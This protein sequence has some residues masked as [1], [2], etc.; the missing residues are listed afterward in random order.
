MQPTWQDNVT[1]CTL[2][3]FNLWPIHIAMK[4]CNNV[5]LCMLIRFDLGPIHIEMKQCNNV[6]QNSILA[7]YMLQCNCYIVSNAWCDIMLTDK[8][9]D[10]DI[11]IK[12]N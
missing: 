10:E 4:Q 12:C 3:R 5:T 1:I 7:K 9:Y 8:S 6:Y 11:I 2:I